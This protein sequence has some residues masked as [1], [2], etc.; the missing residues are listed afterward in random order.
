MD[1]TSSTN[2]IK[3]S[4]ASTQNPADARNAK[5]CK[6]EEQENPIYNQIITPDLLRSKTRDF[7][8]IYQ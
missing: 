2:S 7:K 6:T 4:T 1:I 3:C 8:I 5:A